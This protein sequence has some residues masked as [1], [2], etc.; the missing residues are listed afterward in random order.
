MDEDDK[1]VRLPV[2]FR[3]PEPEDRVIVGMREVQAMACNHLF[4]T[5]VIDEA[6]AEVECGRCKAK[7]N[8]MWVLNRLANEDRRYVESQARY[9]QENARL[10]A[11]QKT[12]CEHCD[13]MTRI[14]HR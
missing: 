8:A 13:K 9:Q 11:R 3:K 5:Y 2:R 7:L 4:A 10:S 1:P 6:A 14:S 12:K